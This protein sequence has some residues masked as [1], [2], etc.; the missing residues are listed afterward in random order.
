[1]YVCMYEAVVQCCARGGICLG[2]P[3]G[4]TDVAMAEQREVSGVACTAVSQLVYTQRKAYIGE[5]SSVTD[6]LG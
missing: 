1:M 6:A 3:G 2:T 4:Q 5:R